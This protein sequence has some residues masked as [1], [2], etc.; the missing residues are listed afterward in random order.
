MVLALCDMPLMICGLGMSPRRKSEGVE[1]E[2]G[3]ARGHPPRGLLNVGSGVA[4]AG[5]LH[6]IGADPLFP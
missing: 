6:R 3:M 1:C 4:G 2:G 5:R